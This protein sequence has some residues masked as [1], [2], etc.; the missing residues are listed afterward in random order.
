MF[1]N[2]FGTRLAATVARTHSSPQ[3]KVHKCWCCAALLARNR[4]PRNNSST[5]NFIGCCC[6]CNW[7]R[8]SSNWSPAPPISPRI[9]SEASAARNTHTKHVV[10]ESRGGGK[11]A[12]PV[13][14]S[15][16]DSGS[17]RRTPDQVSA[18]QNLLRCQPIFGTQIVG[19][20][21]WIRAAEGCCVRSSIHLSIRSFVR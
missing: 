16:A 3:A 1:G 17:C 20:F 15:A 10:R 2:F 14:Y 9:K 11:T 8:Y 21:V 19:A 13:Q 6:C 4:E 5:T 12:V 18:R 7:R